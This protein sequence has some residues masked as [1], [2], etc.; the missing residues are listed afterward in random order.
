MGLKGSVILPISGISESIL[1][2]AESGKTT[3]F[4]EEADVAEDMVDFS[5]AAMPLMGIAERGS[6]RRLAVSMGTKTVL[7]IRVIASDKSTS[8]TENTISDKIFGTSGDSMNM[9]SQYAAC[10][11]NQLIFQPFNGMTRSGKTVSDGV[12]TVTID[13]NVSGAEKQYVT[14]LVLVEAKTQ[15]GNLQDNFDYVMLCLPPGTSGNW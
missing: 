5:F 9:K 15:L 3:I 14:N 13:M 1:A 6:V 7:A 2:S 10:S 4:S 8:S 12:M 11:Y